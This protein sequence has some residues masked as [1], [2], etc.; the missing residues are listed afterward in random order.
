MS[1]QQS[2]LHM[3]QIPCSKGLITAAAT[4]AG[5]AVVAV[6]VAVAVVFCFD[7]IVGVSHPQGV[8]GAAASR[9]AAAAD[10]DDGDRL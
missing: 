10:G 9:A 1:L 2:S 4:A 5:R 6:T 7:D 8:E 3:Q